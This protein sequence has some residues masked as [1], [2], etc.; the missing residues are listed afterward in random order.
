MLRNI[1]LSANS[2]VDSLVQLW[3]NRYLPDLT[4][5]SSKSSQIDV[6]ELFE[7]ASSEGRAKTV[8]KLKRL[9]SINCE[10][11]GIKTNTL[12]SYIPNVVNLTESSRIAKFVTNV[13]EKTLFIYQQQSNS[14]IPMV[15]NSKLF[16]ETI[17][18]STNV[19]AAIKWAMPALEMPAMEQLA[20]ELE[21]VLLELREQHI[22]ARDPRAIGF[23]TTQFH[24]STKLVLAKLTLPEQVLL[25]PYFKFIEE[26]VCIPLQ[27][28]CKAAAQHNLHSPELTIVQQLLPVCRDI[29]TAV[30]NKA[31]SLYHKHSSRRGGLTKPVVA[32]STMRDLEMFQVYL[33]LCVLEG[34]MAAIEQELLPLCIMVFPSVDVSWQ[35][36]EQMLQLLVDELMSRVLPQQNNL[37]L[38]YTQNMQQ[39]FSNIEQKMP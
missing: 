36:V 29:A 14:I 9:I 6:S 4:P 8:A 26:Q 35:L 13:Y 10:C 23:I 18:C 3:A 16:A 28:V 21:P 31:A 39:L 25:N 12:F 33:W 2:S 27:R 20:L 15:V 7:V 32:E 19:D 22:S 30:Y 5:L 37:L 11:A 34:N 24:F 1:N 17:N 38:P